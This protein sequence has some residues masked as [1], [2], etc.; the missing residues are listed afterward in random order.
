MLDESII[1]L[2]GVTAMWM[3]QSPNVVM[4][5]WAAVIGLCGQPAWMWMTW[6]AEQYGVFGLSFVYTASWLRGIKT[7]WLTR[8]ERG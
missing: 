4:R 6:H 5:K 7:Y 8:S 3:T 1:V 2:T